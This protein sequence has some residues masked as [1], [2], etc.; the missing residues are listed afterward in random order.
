MPW[1]YLQCVIVV[2]PDHTHFLVPFS[3]CNH[4]DGDDRRDVSFSLNCLLDV[5]GLLVNL[6]LSHG[7]VHCQ[8]GVIAVFSDNIHFMTLR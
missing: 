2:F 8:P 6:S 3:F 4:L 5:L 1:V 7:G